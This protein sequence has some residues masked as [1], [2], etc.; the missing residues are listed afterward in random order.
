MPQKT[1]QHGRNTRN[2]PSPSF[3]PTFLPTSGN[4][5]GRQQFLS[6]LLN[7]VRMF[8]VFFFLPYLSKLFICGRKLEGFCCL[9]GYCQNLWISLSILKNME[10]ES[11]KWKG[12]KKAKKVLLMGKSWVGKTSMRSI[13]FSNFIARDTRRLAPTSK[14]RLEEHNESVR[15]HFIHRR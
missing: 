10:R 2:T 5:K 4:S 15:I 7:R 14:S 13:I 1:K 11:P 12:V 9:F 8:A 6:D 3:L